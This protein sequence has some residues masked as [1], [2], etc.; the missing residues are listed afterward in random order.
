MW[1][2]IVWGYLSDESDPFIVDF[3]IKT[4]IYRGFSMAMLNNQMVFERVIQ[5]L[6]SCASR[7][8][9]KPFLGEA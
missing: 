9:K 4:I 5:N 7:D 1:E 3:P 8:K 2:D 6:L